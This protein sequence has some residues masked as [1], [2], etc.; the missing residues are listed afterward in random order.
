LGQIG[1]DEFKRRCARGVYM[2][3]CSDATDT[4]RQGLINRIVKL[5]A[6]DTAE[7]AAAAGEA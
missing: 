7:L 1:L 2:L 3:L 5:Q 6:S 4:T